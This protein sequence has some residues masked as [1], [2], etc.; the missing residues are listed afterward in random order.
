MNNLKNT[1]KNELKT[2]ENC[3]HYLDMSEYK[4]E[5]GVC[6]LEPIIHDDLPNG[7]YSIEFMMVHRDHPACKYFEPSLKFYQE[8]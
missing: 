6:L 5:R 7:E 3:K 2:C 8:V 4:C 1:A